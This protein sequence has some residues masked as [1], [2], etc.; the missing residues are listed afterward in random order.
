MLESISVSLDSGPREV[1]QATA[2]EARNPPPSKVPPGVS[3]LQAFCWEYRERGGTEGLA[4]GEEARLGALVAGVGIPLGAADGRQQARVALADL[5]ERRCRERIARCVQRCEPK[6]PAS[7]HSQQ[8][9]ARADASRSPH[10]HASQRHAIR[11]TTVTAAS[12][13]AAA[14]RTPVWQWRRVSQQCK[15]AKQRSDAARL[16][17][18][19]LV[20][21]YFGA[22]I[23]R[24]P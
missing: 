17:M 23:S 14:G 1:V 4:H 5:F 11:A 3:S 13:Q 12:P 16:N 9:L 21:S 19:L 2:G 24:G 7:A 20:L 6:P 8:Q 15:S 10:T 22:E 18:V